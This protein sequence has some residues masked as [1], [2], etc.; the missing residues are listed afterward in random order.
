MRRV[1]QLWRRRSRRAATI[2]LFPKNPYQS[3]YDRFVVTMRRH[4][5]AIALLHQFK[6][7]VGLL[8]PEIQVAHLVDQQELDPREAVEETPRRAVGEAL[9]HLVEELLGLDEEAA[10]AGSG[11]W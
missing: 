2:S 5:P 10:I 4:P 3:S 6:E 8:G 11:G 1:W 7:D 9:V